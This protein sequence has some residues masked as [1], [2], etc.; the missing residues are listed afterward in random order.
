MSRMHASF[1]FRSKADTKKT[2]AR[3]VRRCLRHEI[4]QESVGS[5]FRVVQISGHVRGLVTLRKA[6]NG[7]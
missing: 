5:C 2:I 4:G 6:D 3:P 7:G 1:S